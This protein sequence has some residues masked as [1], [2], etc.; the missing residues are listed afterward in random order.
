MTNDGG[1]RMHGLRAHERDDPA[2]LHY[3]TMDVPVPGIGD[4]LVKVEASS[5]TPTELAWPST[6]VDRAGRDRRPSVPGHEVSGTVVDLG[7]GTTGLSPGD[8]V[9]GITDWYRD[10]A[11]AEYV[12]VEAR[13]LGGKPASIPHVEA[14]SLPLAGLTA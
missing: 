14:A 10:G 3:E 8:E 11:A 4:V 7:Y 12:A 9:F 13:N 6:W 2:G 5:F 1:T